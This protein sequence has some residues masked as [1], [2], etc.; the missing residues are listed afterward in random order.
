MRIKLVI[1]DD[2]PFMREVIRHVM[3][4][5]EVDIIGE[6]ETGQQ[7]IEVV[8]DKKPDVVLMDI[9]MPE[10]TGLEAAKAI[11]A[12]QPE[13]Q[14][15]ACSTESNEEMVLQALE[16][17]CCDFVPKPFK[18]E[19]LLKAVHSSVKKNKEA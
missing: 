7:A 8:L 5:S 9:I 11:L 2:A 18:S 16:V 14:I 10:K 13:T 6:A 17:G 4:G 15:I 19:E 3:A 12:E 1:V